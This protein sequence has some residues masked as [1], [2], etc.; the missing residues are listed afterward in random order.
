MA[1]PGWLRGSASASPHDSVAPLGLISVP[2]C[3]TAPLATW[4]TPRSTMNRAGP[5][6]AVTWPPAALIAR[7]T[8]ANAAESGRVSSSRR[9]CRMASAPRGWIGSELSLT[10]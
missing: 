9:P 7:R 8:G 2:F 6:L 10:S 3:V 5:V 4:V 1:G